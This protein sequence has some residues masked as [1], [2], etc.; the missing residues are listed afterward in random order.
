MIFKKKAADVNLN[1]EL[2]DYADE[3][4]YQ[5]GLAYKRAH[6]EK[7]VILICSSSKAPSTTL[8][9]QRFNALRNESVT[10]INT[11]N[12]FERDEA[13]Q[14][15]CGGSRMLEQLRTSGYASYLARGSVRSPEAIRRLTQS[16]CKALRLQRQNQP[17]AVVEIV[18]PCFYRLA[19]RPQRW[20]SAQEIEPLRQWF[21][22]KIEPE[23]PEE[24]LKEGRE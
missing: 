18:F 15:V 8:N 23:Y 3:Q 11:L 14:L 10:M 17:F 1:C 2:H 16:L 4:F 5:D 13:G 20:M 22:S 24:I 19:G 12:W 6:P 7:L 9:Q 21:A